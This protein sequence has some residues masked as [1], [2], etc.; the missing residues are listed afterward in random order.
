MSA[1]AEAS[2]IAFQMS[3]MAMDKHTSNILSREVPRV[4]AV[5]T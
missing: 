2:L 1:D 5:R 3:G 4:Y